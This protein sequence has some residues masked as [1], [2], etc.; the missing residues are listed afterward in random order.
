MKNTSTNIV[1]LTSPVL[2]TEKEAREN[3]K[4][5]AHLQEQIDKLTLQ[6]SG[7]FRVY[8]VYVT[9]DERST[10][11]FLDMPPFYEEQDPLIY[12]SKED[13]RTRQKELGIQTS[14]ALTMHLFSDLQT[15]TAFEEQLKVNPALTNRIDTTYYFDNEGSY[16]KIVDLPKSIVK[17]REPL[18]DDDIGG[19]YISTMT[20]E[21]FLY[22]KRVL[23]LMKQRLEDYQNVQKLFPF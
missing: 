4:E 22:A 18:F 3:T 10:S 13:N 20:A 11:I 21:D 2:L 12:L 9:R 1:I 15:L 23:T 8:D 7:K 17:Q 19:E 16:G 14:F 6:F 5:L